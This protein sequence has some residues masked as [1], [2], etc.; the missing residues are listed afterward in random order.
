[1]INRETEQT[2]DPSR[3]DA[4][5]IGLGTEHIADRSRPFDKAPQT[6]IGERGK[7]EVNGVTVR[8]VADCVAKAWLDSTGHHGKPDPTYADIYLAPVFRPDP[9]AIVQNAC[10]E[11]EKR[12]G[13]FPNVPRLSLG[14][15]DEDHARNVLNCAQNLNAAM[16]AA[17]A[18]GLNPTVR[19][20][21]IDDELAPNLRPFVAGVQR[22]GVDVEIV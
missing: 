1:M 4:A 18:A 5:A 2:A 6:F 14:I 22:D 21:P 10:V 20:K 19:V 15:D 12:M 11:L 8:D 7:Q 9:M 3:E 16:A 13:I 17:R